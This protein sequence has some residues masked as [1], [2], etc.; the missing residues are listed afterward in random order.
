MTKGHVTPKE[1][2]LEGCAH[3]PP[4]VAQY[5]PYWGIFTG[6]DVIKRHVTPKGL[7]WKGEVCACATESC[8]ISALVGSFH[9]KCPLGCSLGRP[10]PISS[11]VTG[12]SPF[13]GYLPLSRHFIFMGNAFNNYISY[14]SL[15]FSDMFAMYSK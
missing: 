5:P 14:K 4:E 11:V 3:A 6:N 15:L 13:T 1:F 2:P 7:I 10:R 12:T 8:T 9:L